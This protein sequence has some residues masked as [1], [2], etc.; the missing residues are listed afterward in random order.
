MPKE[1]YVGTFRQISFFLS[2]RSCRSLMLLGE[3]DSSFNDL[4]IRIVDRFL[5]EK[6]LYI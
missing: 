6:V 5:S 4:A 1:D 2:E 3:V